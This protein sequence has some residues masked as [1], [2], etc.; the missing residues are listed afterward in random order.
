MNIN[1]IFPYNIDP[2]TISVYLGRVIKLDENFE[3][4]GSLFIDLCDPNGTDLDKGAKTANKAT[5]SF[6]VRNTYKCWTSPPEIKSK[7][8]F[9]GA[10]T[11]TMS[12][13]FHLQN[14]CFDMQSI[15]W[16]STV[17]AALNALGIVNIP[18]IM[19][20]MDQTPFPGKAVS[21]DLASALEEFI[22]ELLDAFLREINTDETLETI[23]TPKS[24]Y[25]VKFH[26]KNKIAGASVTLDPMESVIYNVVYPF[27]EISNVFLQPYITFLKCVSSTLQLVKTR[28]PNIMDW[29][30]PI[31]NLTD[32][33]S[34]EDTLAIRNAISQRID[35]LSSYIGGTTWPPEIM[36][37][38]ENT[39]DY[40]IE[41]VYNPMSYLYTN[42]N[43]T[44][45]DIVVPLKKK[46][47]EVINSN[48]R[49]PLLQ[50]A[51]T[52]A[53]SIQPMVS[54]L[55]TI[56][57][58][59]VKYAIK[60]LIRTLLGVPINSIMREITDPIK[61]I[62][63]D[64]IKSIGK[65]TSS[66]ITSFAGSL[67]NPIIKNIQDTIYNIIP[68]FTVSDLKELTNKIE[69]WNTLPLT[70]P[71]PI[72]IYIDGTIDTKKEFEELNWSNPKE[73]S[74]FIIGLIQLC[75]QSAENPGS[76]SL[77][78]EVR[79]IY[80]S[81]NGIPLG[82]NLTNSSE[83]IIHVSCYENNQ[84]NTK[85]ILPK[86]ALVEGEITYNV[87]DNGVIKVK[88][89]TLFFYNE[90]N[91][92]DEFL[93]LFEELHTPVLIQA[94][95]SDSNMSNL[96]IKEW[97]TNK[98]PFIET[99]IDG[100]LTRYVVN[101]TESD[102]IVYVSKDKTVTL[103]PDCIYLSKTIPHICMDD[104]DLPVG[105]DIIP[106]YDSDLNAIPL[107]INKV[108][109]KGQLLYLLG[110][111][112]FSKA[113]S[114]AD[115]I[116]WSKD[117]EKTF[118]EIVS[119]YYTPKI[120]SKIEENDVIEDLVDRLNIAVSDDT[121]IE[122]AILNSI[123][124]QSFSN[125]K[126]TRKL[127]DSYTSILPN[128]NTELS[129]T[130]TSSSIVIYL[131]TKLTPEKETDFKMSLTLVKVGNTFIVSGYSK[132]CFIPQKTLPL[133]VYSYV[134][135]ANVTINWVTLTNTEGRFGSWL[136]SYLG[137]KGITVEKDY[138]IT[139]TIEMFTDI[140]QHTLSAISQNNFD[141]LYLV[142]ALIS[143]FTSGFDKIAS[144]VDEIMSRINAMLST[145]NSLK[146]LSSIM[147]KLESVSDVIQGV[148]NTIE[149]ALKATA[150]AASAVAIQSCSM[151]QSAKGKDFTFN[152]GDS[153]DLS[154][155]TTDKAQL[156]YCKE[157]GREQF[158]EP[159]CKVLVLAIGA[160]KQNLF[161]VDVLS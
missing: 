156:P 3:E 82:S 43:N 140:L 51:N 37:V 66:F 78:E 70:T 36:E 68:V 74:A 102:I 114:E 150:Q 93:P 46:L 34:S 88:P 38:Y 137:S 145:I 131:R 50:I 119:A 129:F 73:V 116:N 6:S 97:I 47:T 18:P 134:E 90:F 147:D 39:F 89:N 112:D 142:K 144:V 5:A 124:Y 155:T 28:V 83:D 33:S 31:T 80:Q 79:S 85:L 35:D 59:V 25:E 29:T 128:P 149:P 76:L 154:T 60:A 32:T 7:T 16:F 159:N 23:F 138:R 58:L 148:A 22:N 75:K 67:V 132:R 11:A 1:D 9:K 19:I 4:N 123:L 12:G 91:T 40:I 55:P 14:Y 117:S 64:S 52:I 65:Q 133:Q 105:E 108:D 139:K 45:K 122:T 71:V 69:S 2:N 48:I 125:G 120:P 158:L 27:T 121:S 15:T 141:V 49:K 96:E 107:K 81:S 101:N 103:K 42:L 110:F 26:V 136:V 127:G 146:E 92:K 126:S 161:V 135:N 62:L 106:Q 153:Y 98:V 143:K 99:I 113:V 24:L 10:M 104:S 41:T 157:L 13:D 72:D 20:S 17:S 100:E 94:R 54:S 115:K 152:S 95:L 109:D 86:Q 30:F 87:N 111:D 77:T 53:M 63:S 44:I 84:Y 151:T 21:I 118:N 56:V 57:Q 130:E 160:G 8:S 61:S